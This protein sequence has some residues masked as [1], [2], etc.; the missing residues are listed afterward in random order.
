MQPEQSSD[1]DLK[2]VDDLKDCEKKF[3]S[4]S[5]LSLILFNHRALFGVIKD[6]CRHFNSVELL[7]HYG[8]YMKIRVPKLEKT[9]GFVFGLM[10]THKYEFEI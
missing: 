10:E 8:E 6:L 1:T 7:E 4:G 9:V 5:Q 2:I 3:I